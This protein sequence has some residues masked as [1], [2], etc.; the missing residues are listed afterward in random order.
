MTSTMTEMVRPAT[1]PA[2]VAP[3]LESLA[4]FHGLVGWSAPMQALVERIRRVAPYDVP[5]LIVGETGTGKALVAR[6][7]HEVSGRRPGPFAVLTCG[8]P[9]PDL[10]PSRPVDAESASDRSMPDRQVDPLEVLHGGTL[11]LDEIGDL[12]PDGQA[13]VCQVATGLGRRPAG[14]GV[15]L[16]ATTQRD[17]RAAVH[18]GGFRTDLY[19]ALRRAVLVVPPLRARLDDLP[20]L[21]EHIRGTVNARHGVAIEGVTDGALNRLA[22]HPW[23][24]NVRELEAVL[25]EAMLL[26]G[27]G[28]LDA[29]RLSLDRSD[30]TFRILAEPGPEDRRARARARQA[31]ALELA[32]RADGVATRELARAAGTGLAWARRELGGLVAQ[33]RLRRVGRGRAAHYVVA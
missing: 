13:Q 24:G 12:A 4:A 26:Q 5:V 18:A 20:R 10:V 22:A 17:L 33:G 11:L 21:V 19:Y 30:L 7:L 29:D 16:V 15:R 3:P 28:W 9:M 6:A 14:A 32:A 27:Q 31:I 8:A 25:E 1:R 23:P 2:K